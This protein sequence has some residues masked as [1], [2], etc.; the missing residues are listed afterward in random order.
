MKNAITSTIPHRMAVTIA[1]SS[2]LVRLPQPIVQQLEPAGLRTKFS[3]HNEQQPKTGIGCPS[4]AGSGSLF[5]SLLRGTI[6][7][8]RALK[9]RG[10]R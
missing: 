10:A 9:F 6:G 1:R 7:I 8:L 2:S 5:Q 3:A 4:P